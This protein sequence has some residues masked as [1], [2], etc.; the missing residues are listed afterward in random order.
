MVM[1]NAALGKPRFAAC[2]D[3][4]ASTISVA[5]PRVPNAGLARNEHDVGHAYSVRIHTGD[6]RRTI[7]DNPLVVINCRSY[8]AHQCASLHIFNREV[9]TWLGTQVSPTRC[10]ALRVAVQ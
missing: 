1:M 5:G 6:T 9:Q 10:T 8:P 7:Y 2:L 3:F 4:T